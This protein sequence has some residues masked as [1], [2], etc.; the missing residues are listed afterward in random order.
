MSFFLRPL[1]QMTK[2]LLESGVLLLGASITLLVL[3]VLL[4]VAGLT[5]LLSTTRT[6]N[7]TSKQTVV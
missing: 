7:K 3:V 2:R 6:R 4:P 1:L 5:S